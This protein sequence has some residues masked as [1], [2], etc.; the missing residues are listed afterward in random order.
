[1]MYSGDD[2]YGDEITS[3]LYRPMPNVRHIATF[4]SRHG[5]YQ[6]TI[7]LLESGS[8]A[9]RVHD[10][11]AGETLPVSRHF[12]TEERARAYALECVTDTDD[13]ELPL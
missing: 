11:D 4:E 10:V 5:G 1:M 9:V 2:Y 13:E 12:K 3:P 8:Y 7:T 6:A